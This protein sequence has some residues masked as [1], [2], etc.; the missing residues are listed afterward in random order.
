[1]F[2]I[3]LIR[4]EVIEMSEAILKT[5]LNLPHEFKVSG[6]N[7]IAIWKFYDNSVFVNIKI[8][9]NPYKYGVNNIYVYKNEEF[10]KITSKL[11]INDLYEHFK[12]SLND[13]YVNLQQS[14]IYIEDIKNLL[15]NKKG[16]FTTETQKIFTINSEK[17]VLEIILD[18]YSCI[19]ELQYTTGTSK[20]RTQK[21]I[22]FDKLT[23]FIKTHKEK[24]S[25]PASQPLQQTQTPTTLNPPTYNHP[26][27]IAYVRDKVIDNSSVKNIFINIPKK[28]KILYQSCKDFDYF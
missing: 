7:P 1:M 23:K 21:N 11:P 6:G 4:I 16:I 28:R 10:D 8:Y 20:K 9:L 19:I 14:K 3:E 22:T 18:M 27:R 17:I 25:Q 12:D 24:W 26:R 15:G 2:R 5:F 13:M